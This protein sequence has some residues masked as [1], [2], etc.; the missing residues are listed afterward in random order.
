MA[1]YGHQKTHHT[2]SA[3]LRLILASNERCNKS[4]SGLSA[5]VASTPA[6]QAIPATTLYSIGWL[7][8]LLLTMPASRPA[9][10]ASS[11]LAMRCVRP[12]GAK[13]LLGL[14]IRVRAF[15]YLHNSLH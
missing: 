6:V 3:R 1:E 10:G 8:S 2:F 4:I 7:A 11:K 9:S 13:L 15:L 14:Y 5:S 12:F